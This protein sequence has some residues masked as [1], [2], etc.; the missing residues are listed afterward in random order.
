[1]DETD[2][3]VF[4]EDGNEVPDLID[5]YLV[6][7]VEMT[8]TVAYAGGDE[9]YIWLSVVGRERSLRPD[10]IRPRSGRR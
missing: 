8:T 4:D 1:M 3:F 7:D 6:P 9:T 5:E 2:T 10:V